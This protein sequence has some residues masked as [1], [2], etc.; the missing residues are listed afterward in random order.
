M[1]GCRRTASSFVKSAEDLLKASAI[2]PET[3]YR[4]TMTICSRYFII[5]LL[6]CLLLSTASLAAPTAA[7]QSTE[8][9]RLDQQF[10]QFTAGLYS[11]HAPSLAP[12]IFETPE[13]LKTAVAQHLANKEPL[14][15]AAAVHTNLALVQ[16]HIN[17]PAAIDYIALL[18]DQNAWQAASALH[19]LAQEEGS[20][21][22]ISNVSYLVA[23][24]HFERNDWQRCIELLDGITADLPQARAQHALLMQGIAL[25]K[26]KQHRDALKFYAKI[27]STSPYYVQARMNMA[28]A[29]IRQDWWT[30]AHIIINDLLKDPAV[31]GDVQTQDRLYTMLGYSFL[32]QRFYRNARESFRNVGQDSIY[33]HQALL[34]IAL[35]AG[36]Q[37]DH[38]GALNA[39]RLLKDSHKPVLP[40]DEA[41]LL[42]PYFYEKLQQPATA[43][44]AYDEAVQYFTNHIAA[45]NAV[46]QI[47]LS[48]FRQQHQV[49]RDQRLH[50]QNQSIALPKRMPRA[51][52][53]HYQQ[54][55]Q[56]RAPLAALA[57]PQLSRQFTQL[58]D[59]YAA[60][61]YTLTHEALNERIS[62]LSHY[63]NQSRYSIARLFDTHEAIKP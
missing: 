63:L 25:Q 2:P 24:H 35:A 36:H 6:A 16:A 52:L 46:L 56:Y 17:H 41:Y 14:L 59:A 3:L 54:L 27:S 39:A 43:S 44:A 62:Q 51:F 19:A 13:Q 58:E 10:Q 34:G 18:L 8:F 12:T 26:L 45:I 53:H 31:A 33:A 15:A 28:V 23:R 47:D 32:Q 29:N 37:D 42:L 9:E 48:G 60:A 40:V 55:D 61:L 7:P 57:D 21:A 30:D 5:A 11:K 4:P 22:L 1:L 38:I 50:F 20:K 49:E